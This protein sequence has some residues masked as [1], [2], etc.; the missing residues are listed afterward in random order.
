M[1]PGTPQNSLEFMPEIDLPTALNR[2]MGSRQLLTDL[3]KEFSKK[4]EGFSTNVSKA[5]A[6]ND[7]QTARSMVHTFKG[8]SGTL[9]LGNLYREAEKLEESLAHEKGSLI[10]D[11]LAKIDQI[12]IPVIQSINSLP[13]E[14][15]E[16]PISFDSQH[17]AGTGQ[18]ELNRLLASLSD[19]LVRHNLKAVKQ[20]EETKRLLTDGTSTKA[21]LEM[22]SHIK[23]LDFNSAKKCL[24]GIAARLGLNLY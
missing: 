15:V 24:D 23:N 1:H 10:E 20:F 6:Q 21:I 17:H 13:A 7:F 3:L 19:S 18:T 2:M 4:Y 12:L 9:S 14:P 11:R 16:E 8:S 22:E 5:L